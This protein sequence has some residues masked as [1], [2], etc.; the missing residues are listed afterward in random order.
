MLF[1]VPP[2]EVAAWPASEL[3]LI[4]HYLAAQPAPE[5][6]IELAV[7]QLCAM[8]ANVHRRQG[9]AAIEVSEFLPYR[10][11]FRAVD[12]DRYSDVDRSFLAAFGVK[13]K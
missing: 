8:F 5:E 6:R 10:D 7:A 11:P 2:H 1:R 3:A 4:E 9:S 12:A 13:L